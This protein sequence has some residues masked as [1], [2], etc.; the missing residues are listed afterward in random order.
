[1][2][3]S[4]RITASQARQ[5]VGKKVYALKKD[6]TIVSGR[7]AS[8]KGSKLYLQTPK[9]KASTKA[10]L[11]LALFDLLAIG[12]APYAY[13]G[14]GGYPGFGLGGFGYGPYG[15]GAGYPGIFI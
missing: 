14:F 6:G 8:V 1:M 3:K 4:K 10:I 9:G 11:P 7:L 2:A 13:G 5:L 12:T 15:F